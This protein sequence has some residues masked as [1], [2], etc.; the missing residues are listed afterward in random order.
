M[1][2]YSKEAA[3]VVPGFETPNEE[4]EL[5]ALEGIRAEIGDLR[6]VILAYSAGGHSLSA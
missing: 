1:R 3:L 4:E 6:R 5:E 2:H